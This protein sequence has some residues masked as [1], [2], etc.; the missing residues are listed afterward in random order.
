MMNGEFRSMYQYFTVF[1]SFM[2]YE[3]MYFTTELE[4]ES[5]LYD[6]QI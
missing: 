2:I 1:V 5:C 6:L 3:S 4:F